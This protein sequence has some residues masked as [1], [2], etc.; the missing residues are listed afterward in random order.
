[1]F[2]SGSAVPSRR[3]VLLMEKVAQV[4]KS[5]RGTV[6]VRGFTDNKP[7]RGGRYDNWHLSLDRAQVTHY[8]L[9]RGGLDDTRIGHIEG[10]A[11]RGAR[12][13]ADAASPLNRRIEILVKDDQ[14]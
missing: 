2:S 13:G 7:F 14:P 1:M 11:D 6:I 10:F 9:V 3:I 4:L 12:P 5:R 8:M